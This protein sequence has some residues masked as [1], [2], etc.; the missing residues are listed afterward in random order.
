M[1][2]GGEDI[3]LPA[4]ERS[5]QSWQNWLIH[6][7]NSI[8]SETHSI[9]EEV[10]Q[11]FDAAISIYVRRA[12]SNDTNLPSL[13]PSQYHDMQDATIRSLILRLACISPDTHGAH[14]LV[15]PCFIAG[16]EA[17]DPQQRAFLVAY[18]N[19]I[20]EKTMFRN[21]PIAVQSLENLWA[22]KGDKRWTQC[23]PE[24]SKVLVM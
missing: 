13:P 8:D 16:A 6:A 24:I 21:I 18:M 2:L 17:S 12:T 15:W 4:I 14:A 5:F 11:C 3:G 9:I 23:L 20:Y 7:H 1:P 22:S 10:R 19:G